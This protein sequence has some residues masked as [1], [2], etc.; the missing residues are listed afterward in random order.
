MYLELSRS[1][2]YLKRK[3]FQ[4]VAVLFP[5]IKITSMCTNI[6]EGILLGPFHSTGTEEKAKLSLTTP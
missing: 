6:V 5:L 3:T 4:L 2:F 1:P